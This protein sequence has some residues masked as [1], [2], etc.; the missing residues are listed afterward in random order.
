MLDVAAATDTISVG[1]TD[2]ISVG[3]EVASLRER[4][5]VSPA[6]GRF[7]CLS[8][9]EFHAEGEWVEP[10]TLLGEVV[11]QGRRVPVR[12][13]WRGWVM[14]MLALDNQPV[15]QGEALFWIRGC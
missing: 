2:T 13:P 8:P 10:G 6:P 11:A 7:T 4:L 9:D 3:Q 14:G 1:Q 15:K 5:V 12:S